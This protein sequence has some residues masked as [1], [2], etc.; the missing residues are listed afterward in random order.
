M[1]AQSVGPDNLRID[2]DA[3][4]SAFC[5]LCNCA[6]G[7]DANRNL[8]V[9]LDV[10]KSVEYI[11][12]NW[13]DPYVLASAAKLIAN[14]AYSNVYTAMMCLSAHCEEAL[15]MSIR[16][17]GGDK[18][19]DVQEAA[20]MAFA[21]LSNNESNQTHVGASGAIELAVQVSPAARR[22]HTCVNI[23]GGG[24]NKGQRCLPHIVRVTDTH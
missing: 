11:C 8:I 9:E 22:S 7:N 10:M 3:L 20:M 16:K 17:G 15:N 12:E 18:N 6:E 13:T 5:G 21:N 14:L 1:F 2:D 24:V 19:P 23:I 4:G